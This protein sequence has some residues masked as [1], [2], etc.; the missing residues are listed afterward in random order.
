MKK[1]TLEII[2]QPALKQAT[3]KSVL[4]SANE[5]LYSYTGPQPFGEPAPEPSIT[6]I[7]SQM[8]KDCEKATDRYRKGMM[9]SSSFTVKH[10]DNECRIYKVNN[11][12]EDALLL[13]FRIT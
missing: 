1:L 2:K 12:N 9:I 7:A 11:K 6:Q 4:K 13:I 8:K 5:L 10:S 3:I